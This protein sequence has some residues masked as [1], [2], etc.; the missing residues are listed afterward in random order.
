MSTFTP[1]PRLLLAISSLN[2]LSSPQLSAFLTQ[3]FSSPLSVTPLPTHASFPIS[4]TLQ[5]ALCYFFISIISNREPFDLQSF[6]VQASLKQELVTVFLETWG[7][8]G[9]EFLKKGREKMAAVGGKVKDIG[10]ELGVSVDEGTPALRSKK[11][12]IE[13]KKGKKNKPKFFLIC[14]NF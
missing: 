6:L 12:N 9:G 14:S 8:W 1:S 5:D 4:R 7:I 13:T 3:T 11:I 2:S 10:W